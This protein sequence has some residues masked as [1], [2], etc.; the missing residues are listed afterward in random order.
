MGATNLISRN[1]NSLITAFA[2]VVVR[3]F[4]QDVPAK[5]APTVFAATET[6]R[7]G[8]YAGPDNRQ[9]MAEPPVLVGRSDA[10]ADL[11]CAARL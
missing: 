11:V 8:S 3:L 7:G 2:K 1:E 4:A 9:E 5:A 10:A 6:L